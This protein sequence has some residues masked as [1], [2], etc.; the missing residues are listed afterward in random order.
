MENQAGLDE[1]IQWDVLT[2]SKAL[3][4]WDKKVNWDGVHTALELGAREGGISL[5][6]AQKG[7]Q[8]LCSDYENAEVTALPLHQKFGVTDRISYQDIDATQI[9]HENHFDLIVFKSI[10]GGIGKFG[11]LEAQKKVFEQIHKAL[12]PGGVLLYAENLVSSS[13]H[14]YMRKKYNAWGDY[15]RY[16]SKEELKD[17]LTPYHFASIHTTGFWATFGRSERQKRLLTRIDQLGPNWMFP[18]TWKYMGFGIAIKAG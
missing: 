4:Y 11:G 1:I 10:V 5:W 8:V 15:W 12:K 14:Q 2:W 18:S 13:L 16:L 6:L 9:P 3:H 7:I 17:F